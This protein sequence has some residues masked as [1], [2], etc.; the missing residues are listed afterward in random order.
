[1]IRTKRTQFTKVIS[2]INI[3]P[4]TD[5]CLV[6]LIIFMVAY[7]KLSQ[8]RRYN[9][10]LPKTTAAAA[11]MPTPVTVVIDKDTHLFVN[12]QQV[13][14]FDELGER[15]TALHNKYQT[16]ILTLRVDKSLPCQYFYSAIDT[17]KKSGIAN[18]TLA[19]EQAK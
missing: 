11:P 4:F 10:N 7:P 19:T 6:L 2:D 8:E 18:F 17:A 13:K 9:V 14:S 16:E 3:T 15:L 5:V 12:D 1:M